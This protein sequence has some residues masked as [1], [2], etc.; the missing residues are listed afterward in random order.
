MEHSS[1]DKHNE[2]IQTDNNHSQTP[3]GEEHQQTI[4]DESDKTVVQDFTANTNP[5]DSKDQATLGDL[6]SNRYRLI[7][8][9]GTGGMSHVYKAID[10][11]AE[12]AGDAEPF[13]AIK[14]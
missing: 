7:E 10:I 9:I 5:A 11:F 1:D 4:I 13:V 6:L 12:K 8:L 2:Q 14:F 3:D